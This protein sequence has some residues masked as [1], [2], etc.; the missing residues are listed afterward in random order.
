MEFHSRY[1]V[2]ANMVVTVVG[3]VEPASTMQL[4]ET[5]FA[6]LEKRPKPPPLRTVEPKQFAER[7]VVVREATQPIYVE[8]YHK[9]ASTHPDEAVFDVMGDLLSNGRTSRLYRSLV[10]DKQIAAVSAGFPGFPGT[11][12]ANMFVAY[13]IPTPGHTPQELREAIHEQIERLKNED[14]TEDELRMV[15]ARAKANLIRQL[16]SNQGLALQLGT[17]QA[18]FGDWRE[19]FRHVERI[20]AV[21]AADVRR[22]ANEYFVASN[23][24]VGIIESTQAAQAAPAG[25]R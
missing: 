12:Y 6:R 24:T 8:G 5:Y 10:R 21:T 4:I 20:D 9:V 7:T 25:G 2:P 19:L 11:K 18:M 13:A 3:D 23:R 14:V 17:A 22:V 15:K 1:Y 16:D